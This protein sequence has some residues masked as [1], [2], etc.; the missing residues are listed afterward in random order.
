MTRMTSLVFVVA[1][2]VAALPG[3]AE[4][5]SCARLGSACEAFWRSGA[6]FAGEVIE[7]T[8]HD[9]RK[10]RSLPASRRARFRVLEAFVGVESTEIEVFT[11]LYEASCGYSFASG[12]KYLVFAFDYPDGRR[13]VSLCS[14]TRPMGPLNG[15]L[16]YLRSLKTS[17]H[18][19][20]RVRGR[21]MYVEGT[22]SGG[23][24]RGSPFAGARIVA[25]SGT[26]TI[27][28]VSDRDGRF[29]LVAPVGTYSLSIEVSDGLH[30]ATFTPVVHIR[31]PEA[32][33]EISVRVQ[34]DSHISGRLVS[35]NGAPIPHLA[36]A[37]GEDGRPDKW[38]KSYRVIGRTD[39]EG[40]FDIGKLAPGR[41]ALG[42]SP[43]RMPGSSNWGRMLTVTDA[44]GRS[45]AVTATLTAGGRQDVGDIVA[46]GLP[47]LVT[48]SGTVVDMADQPL[49]NVTVELN[50]AGK[51]GSGIDHPILTDAAGRFAFAVVES[52][53]YR[54]VARLF[55]HGFWGAWEEV[56][57][58]V[59]PADVRVR[60]TGL[61]STAFHK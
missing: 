30:A 10:D 59:A 26:K 52:S 13:G 48:L 31:D 51:Q 60:G 37:V 7:I 57:D 16:R 28:S 54:L 35:E 56:P 3:S 43:P 38:V 47:R 20:G 6:V 2:L 22:P 5:C 49:R 18:E 61:F 17:A 33:G 53:R 40:R 39:A 23:G 36:L 50:L 45:V 46:R 15:D 14:L 42:V 44:T 21:A 25:R 24:G 1:T 34:P 29:E 58:V 8:D 11:E 32:C 4:A 9:L 19:T 55:T 27:E 12:G 41:Y